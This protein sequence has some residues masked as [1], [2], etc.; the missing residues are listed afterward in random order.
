MV[1][2]GVGA[3]R[4]GPGGASW[5]EAGEE[6]GYLA[7][8]VE[9]GALAVFVGSRRVL[10]EAFEGFEVLGGFV[11]EFEAGVGVSLVQELA[12]LLNRLADFG[13]ADVLE[14]GGEGD[15]E[16]A[17]DLGERDVRL[18]PGGEEAVEVT[19][20][21]VDWYGLK[22][23]VHTPLPPRGRVCAHGGVSWESENRKTK[24]EN[25]EKRLFFLDSWRG[26]GW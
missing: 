22:K 17:G 1:R 2:S 16:V 23:V 25:E 12:G 21:G 11:E 3:L 24:S 14:E 15:A 4:A 26:V 10:G 20:G 19:G 6:G 7:H 8:A 9:R 13:M 5:G 18:E